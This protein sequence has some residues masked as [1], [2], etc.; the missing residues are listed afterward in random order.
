MKAQ[1]K[2][3]D[4]IYNDIEDIL[5]EVVPE[6]PLYYNESRREIINDGINVFE[7][8]S[9]DPFSCGGER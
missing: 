6:Q 5:E 3:K 4:V 9:F 2:I 8:C 1:T 7:E